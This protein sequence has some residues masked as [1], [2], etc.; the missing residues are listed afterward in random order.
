MRVMPKNSAQKVMR[1]LM[2]HRNWL[3]S[4]NDDELA[5]HCYMASLCLVQA[6]SSVSYLLLTVM[7]FLLPLT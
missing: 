4:I 2:K 3:V 7:T 6:S 5:N 1:E